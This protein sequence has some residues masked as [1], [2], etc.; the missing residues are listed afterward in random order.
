MNREFLPL[1]SVADLHLEA[2]YGCNHGWYRRCSTRDHRMSPRVAFGRRLTALLALAGVGLVAYDARSETSAS[3]ESPPPPR[4]ITLP[5]ALTYARAHQPQI[6]AA[7]SRIA[8]ERAAA[9]IPRGQWLP[10]IGVTAQLLG[11]TANNTTASYITLPFM[12]IPRIG[13]TRA[14]TAGNASWQPYASTFAGAGL[15]QELFDFGRIA[16]QAAAADAVVEVSQHDADAERLDVEFGVEEAFFAV[17]AAKAVLAASNGAYERSRVHRDLAQRGVT[18]G[19]RS[20][21]E[22]TRAEADLQRFD[23]ARIRAAGNVSISQNVLSA[24]IGSTEPALDAVGE[25]PTPA[26]VPALSRAIE[27]ASARDPHLLSTFARLKQQEQQ[28]RAVG[29]ELRPDLFLTST[30]SGR[31]GG[32]PP[33]SGQAADYSGWLPT[34]PNWDVGVVLSWPIFDGTIDARRTA[35]RTAERVRRDE[36]EVARQQLVANVQQRYVMVQ[37]TR[38]ALPGLE[39]AVK[40]AHAN[41]AQADARFKSG[42]GT[43][44]ELADAEALR[45]STEID[46]AVG[47]FDLARARAAF[48]RAIAE[49][50]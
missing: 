46:Y 42:L 30:L 15:T 8:E 41:Y 40:A 24:A 25:E 23:I 3:A 34:V 35:S 2:S 19:L 26:D 13:G 7:L 11:G 49:G 33:S 17:Q 31:A 39:Q 37:V 50:L 14:T 4:G 1:P 9:Q 20:P 16:A 43:S 10:T 44:V 45:A 12:D 27:L 32:A 5:D 28:T 29:A 47:I 6:R 22:L 18:A 21:I 38:S 36:M 48:G